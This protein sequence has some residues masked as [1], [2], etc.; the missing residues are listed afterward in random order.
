MEK[1]KKTRCIGSS[2]S[3]ILHEIHRAY[4]IPAVV[5]METGEVINEKVF[6]SPRPPP[7]ISLTHDWMKEWMNWFQKLL[8]KQKSPNQP[9]PIQIMKERRVPLCT[10]NQ[11]VHPQ[12]LTRWT[13]TSAYLD[14]HISAVNQAESS[15]VREH[16]EDR[17]PT[18]PTR[19]GFDLQQNKAY[20]PFSEVQ[21]DDWRHG[22][23]GTLLESRNSLLHLWT[24]LTRKCSQPRRHSMYI[25]PSLNSK[26]SH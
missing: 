8:D 15:P 25:G 17:E 3:I 11:S 23:C 5:R 19:S 1:S 21:E 4:C 14:C 6:E 13:S 20:N 24:S 22:Q 9:N 10:H 7:K 26:L 2:N 16:Q 18:S 12:R